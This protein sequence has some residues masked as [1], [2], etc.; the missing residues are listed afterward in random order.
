MAE[1]YP[2]RDMHKKSYKNIDFEQ[3]WSERNQFYC[4]DMPKLS[5]QIQNINTPFAADI[6][7]LSVEGLSLCHPSFDEE[8]VGQTISIK[9]DENKNYSLKGTIINFTVINYSGQ[10]Q[11]R[12]GVEFQSKRNK[13]NFRP[14]RFKTPAGHEAM[15]Y[16]K[17]PF[18]FNHACHY[19][20]H[21]FSAN[22]ITLQ[23]NNVSDLMVPGIILSL[24]VF[25]PSYGIFKT[26]VEITNIRKGKDKNSF[27]M[28]CIFTSPSIHFLTSISSYL[29]SST[30]STC[31]VEDLT[32]N[33]FLVTYVGEF[34]KLGYIS[35][36][37]QWKKL[38]T[39]RRVSAQA[40]GRW[41]GCTDDNK[42]I[43]N[44]DQF[45]RHLYCQLGNQIVAGARLSFNNGDLGRCEHAKY[46][47]IPQFIQDD[48]FIEASRVCT[49]P[50]YRKANLFPIVLQNCVRIAKQSHCRYILFNCEDSLVKIYTRF[51]AKKLNLSF[52]NEYMNGKRLNVLY[53]DINSVLNGK[54]VNWFI[55]NFGFKDLFFH[56]KRKKI[57]TPNLITFLRV[58]LIVL[59]TEP[60]LY[61]KKKKYFKK[62]LIKRQKTLS[63]F[64]QTSEVKSA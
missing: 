19:K 56:L 51:G 54:S 44:Y 20:V 26:E 39:L 48:G 50:N 41:L 4:R 22:G 43:D 15:G 31:S 8:H 34:A 30:Q 12:I 13:I 49:D 40:E 24:Q 33:G 2:V 5:V 32:E 38:L 62:L 53:L 57:I 9:I 28:G 45:A 46:I 52:T 55:W 37:E 64:T 3:R 47:P 11:N 23:G 25:I 58:S 1:S 29:L 7:D 59:V 60:T 42:M 27:F 63:T 16:V 36:H 61:Y 14:K 35:N 6:F 10:K 17:S 18:R 21:D